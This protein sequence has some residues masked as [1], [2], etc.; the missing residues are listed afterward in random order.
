MTLLHETGHKSCWSGV[1]PPPQK[2]N[3]PMYYLTLD[4]GVGCFILLHT[5][6]TDSSYLKKVGSGIPGSA[7]RLKP[8]SQNH[9]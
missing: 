9:K 6:Q 8:V 7:P 4:L 5:S 2:K 1:R 3:P